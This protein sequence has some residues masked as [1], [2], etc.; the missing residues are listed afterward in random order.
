[1]TQR[2]KHLR[3]VGIDGRILHEFL[4]MILKNI[5]KTCLKVCGTAIERFRFF[6]GFYLTTLSDQKRLPIVFLPMPI[7]VKIRR[8]NLV[9]NFE[10]PILMPIVKKT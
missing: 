6:I 2:L 1:M 9:D 3:F 7:G 4:D 10:H 8:I 5:K